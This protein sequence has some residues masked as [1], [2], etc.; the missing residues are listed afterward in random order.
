MG[1]EKRFGKT[2]HLFSPPC[3]P[4]YRLLFKKL[5]AFQDEISKASPFRN[6]HG[7]IRRFSLMRISIT[8]L[9]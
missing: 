6:D 9:N 4:D 7:K 5:E 1:R 3:T 2:N 8:R